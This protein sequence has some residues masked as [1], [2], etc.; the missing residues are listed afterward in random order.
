MYT[1]QDFARL[2]HISAIIWD[3][4]GTITDPNG[5]V[6]HEVAAKIINLG[7][8]GI[9]HLFITGRDAKWI[10]RNV[11][12]PMKR[13]YGFS[14]MHD[15]MVFFAEVGC[16]MLVVDARGNVVEKIH[17]TVENHPLKL[18]TNNIRD[19]LKQLVH[20]PEKLEKY[21]KGK[22]VDPTTHKIVYD[23]DKVGWLVPRT[24]PAPE[25]PQ[26]IW[27]I[28]KKVFATF[29]NLRDAEG[30]P[31]YFDQSS[32]ANKLRGIIQKKGFESQID[33]E[34]VSTAL[35]IVPKVNQNRL[36]KSWAA[37]VALMHLWEEKLGRTFTLD[38]VISKTIAF[39]DGK[40][41]FD[42]TV[43]LFESKIVRGL[44]CNNVQIVFVGE[45]EDLPSDENL[46][47]NIIISAVGGGDLVFARKKQVIELH[48][49]KGAMVVSK[50]LD[51]LKQWNYF[52]A[53]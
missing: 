52:S 15:N 20:N 8:E 39:G 46:R 2:H 47:K 35:N 10:I 34:I 37:A 3:I 30:K 17:S 36:G 9:Y 14:R 51:F 19:D 6:N 22:P 43:P 33:V 45:E 26:H 31:M 23:A 11:I 44:E 49:I 38:E 25:F 28:Y 5:E 16:V 1:V 41:D 18:N 27:S 48:P 24:A 50:V 12:E 13:F 53:F 42:F 29:E 7:L 32:W 4:D 40:A 21:E